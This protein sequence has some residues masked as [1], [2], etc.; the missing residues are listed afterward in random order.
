[1]S[2]IQCTAEERA[3]F[4][5]KR[6]RFKLLIKEQSRLQLEDKLQLRKPHGQHT[7]KIVRDVWRRKSTLTHLF[8]K[9][10]EFRGKLVCHSYSA[11]KG[12]CERYADLA[13]RAEVER[14]LG[15]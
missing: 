11:R 9:Y 13:V 15:E 14:M 4:F 1:M 10:A 6:D 7:W 3:A 12:T 8:I 2:T 5:A